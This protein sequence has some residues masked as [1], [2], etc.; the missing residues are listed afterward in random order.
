[1]LTERKVQDIQARLEIV[2][3]KLLKRSAQETAVS[4]GS[5]FTAINLV[6][7]WSYK[8]NIR[9]GSVTVTTRYPLSAKVGT[10]F[11]TRGS[12]GQY[13]RLRTKA[14]EFS[15]IRSTYVHKLRCYKLCH[16]T[17]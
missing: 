11:D 5:E 16:Y 7:F 6:I 3:V 8:I 17:M 15:F 9:G 10:N 4:L 13:T 1:M 2:L 12:L 14:T